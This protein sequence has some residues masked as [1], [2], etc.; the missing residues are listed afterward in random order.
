MFRSAVYHTVPPSL[1]S[2]FRGRVWVGGL[3]SRHNVRHVGRLGPPFGKVLLS[4][5]SYKLL[6]T[7]G[8]SPPLRLNT[9]TTLGNYFLPIFS[10]FR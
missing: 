4:R 2:P 10:Y 9:P 6:S 1:G 3:L 7:G 5:L 8:E